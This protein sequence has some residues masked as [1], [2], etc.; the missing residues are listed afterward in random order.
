[1]SIHSDCNSISGHTW[2]G[3]AIQI[4]D[5]LF[6]VCPT[7]CWND[8]LDLRVV[9][10]EGERWDRVLNLFL[11][12]RE[13]LELDHYLPFFRLRRL[14]ATSLQLE[15]GSTPEQ[16]SNPDLALLLARSP[17]SLADIKRSIR[18]DWFEHDLELEDPRLVK[19]RVVERGA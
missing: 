1:M 13:R 16:S 6:P 19:V 8:L 18:R 15:A 2:K 10:A 7:E 3:D 11:V 14:L 9:M 17:R 4:I 12:C 5:A